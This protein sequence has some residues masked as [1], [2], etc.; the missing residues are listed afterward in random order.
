MNYIEPG[1]AARMQK[2]RGAAGYVP[3]GTP[4]GAAKALAVTGM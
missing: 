2:N 3:L 4:L 1:R